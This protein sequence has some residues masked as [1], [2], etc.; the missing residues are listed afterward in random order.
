VETKVFKWD[1]GFEEDFWKVTLPRR[2][3]GEE[4]VIKIIL[5]RRKLQYN[6][7]SILLVIIFL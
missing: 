5:R 1:V 6:T 7:S 2:S 3:L 4:T